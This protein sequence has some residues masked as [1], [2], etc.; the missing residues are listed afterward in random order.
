MAVIYA[1]AAPIEAPKP[2]FTLEPM[3][4]SR[5][6]TK[7]VR[8]EN[9][10]VMRDEVIEDAGFMVRCYKGHSVFVTSIDELRR[11]KLDK[12]IPLLNNDDN[13]VAVVPVQLAK[14]G[15]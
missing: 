12:M 4:R 7:C 6:I 9:G 2:A 1:G 13:P 8:D 10:F 15:N 11:M 3:T 14:K 5:T